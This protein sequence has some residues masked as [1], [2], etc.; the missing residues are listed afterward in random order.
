ML[1]YQKCILNDLIKN[2]L[3]L[4]IFSRG[5]GL[6]DIVYYFLK[7]INHE[8]RD[9][10]IILLNMTNIE[11]EC[12]NERARILDEVDKSYL[13]GDSLGKTNLVDLITADIPLSK[14]LNIYESGG[15][16]MITSRILITDALSRKL[17]FTKV[18]GIIVM[19]AESLNN[20][21][22]NDAFILQVYK[23]KNP[24]GFIK[25]LSQRPELLKV[26]YFGPGIAM[27]HIGTTV[28]CL[29][30]RSHEAM[31]KSLIEHGSV[32]VTERA[33]RPTDNFTTV[34][35]YIIL[36]IEKGFNEL[37]KVNSDADIS[38]TDT[39]F[40]SVRNFQNC[41]EEATQTKWN[42]MSP[43]LRN[44]SRDIVTF[45]RLLSLLH[46]LDAVTF[47][48]YTEALRCTQSLDFSWYLTV[49][50]EAMYK[51]SRDRVFQ[52]ISRKDISKGTSN[53]VQL[54]L[55]VNPLYIEL[56]DVLKNIGV[57]L[58]EKAIDEMSLNMEK[59]ANSVSHEENIDKDSVIDGQ[60]EEDDHFYNPKIISRIDCEHTNLPLYKIMIVVPDDQYDI[61][62]DIFYL[63][64]YGPQQLALHHFRDFCDR[65]NNDC[66]SL[67]TN[68]L[69]KVRNNTNSLSNVPFS[70]SLNRHIDQ[71][72]AA[73]SLILETQSQRKGQL[74]NTTTITSISCVEY[75][76]DSDMD[77]FKQIRERF[78]I[79]PI[80][81]ITTPH[82]FISGKFSNQLQSKQ[83][84]HII[85]LDPEVATLR[86]IEF[87]NAS[88]RLNKSSNLKVT[89]LTYQGSFNHE[90]FINTMKVEQGSWEILIRHKRT[91][92]VPLNEISEDDVINH[93]NY[94]LGSSRHAGRLQVMHVQKVVVDI[95]EFRS[96]LPYQLYCKGIEVVPVTLAVGDYVI[97]RDICIERKSIQDLVNS[98]NSGR[99]YTQMQWLTTHYSIPTILIEFIY[100]LGYIK[101]KDRQSGFSPLPFNLAEIYNK[102][103]LLIRHFP[104]VKIIWS[105]STSF[106]ASSIAFLKHGRE[107]PDENSATSLYTSLL[108][109]E[110]KQVKKRKRISD[111]SKS[112]YYATSLLRQLPGVNTKNIHFV[113]SNFKSLRDLSS[114]AQEKLVDLLGNS[115]GISLFRA[116]HASHSESLHVT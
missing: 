28:L 53:S 114:A 91:L 72:R 24:N 12:L 81:I 50:F 40:S 63:V 8:K 45:R 7:E 36:L 70:T 99:L 83:P 23:Q 90:R 97:S 102:L 27:K 107:E 33:V 88:G 6:N 3:C 49:E 89:I 35:R 67:L 42:Q 18:K 94:S 4:V 29:Y 76:E 113:T 112:S 59:Q 79:E 32:D 51:A 103:I 34:Q 96:S 110:D 95:R 58:M 25:G 14:R 1:H 54:S 85:L 38:L 115:N 106:S 111:A 80:I 56:V 22:W 5:L 104:N 65:L 71:L 116:L 19:N 82:S 74:S 2:R 26:G 60:L 37:K 10:S 31:E 93:L 105:C 77:L 62:N 55:E 100:G 52:I 21:N 87:F 46:R 84:H 73:I 66:N 11:V 69:S 41:I 47:F 48:Y 20:K 108:Y 109:E 78:K 15:T 92:V 64:N 39:L 86:E 57:D 43:H 101:W 98:L 17:D 75:S 16:F 30:P 68:T 13:Q 61:I 9:K 44:I